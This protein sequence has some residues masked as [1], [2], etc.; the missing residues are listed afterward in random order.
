M[1]RVCSECEREHGAWAEKATYGEK[2]PL[3]GQAAAD[4]SHVADLVP[5]TLYFCM[6][7]RCRVT[8]FLAGA[9]GRTHGLCERHVEAFKRSMVEGGNLQPQTARG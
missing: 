8:E 4:I 9:G 7:P 6:T 1:T 2:C 5:D 3:C